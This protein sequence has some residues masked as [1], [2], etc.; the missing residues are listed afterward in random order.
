MPYLLSDPRPVQCSI[1]YVQI[2]LYCPAANTSI[3]FRFAAVTREKPS[4]EQLRREAEELL[5]TAKQL[6][7]KASQLLDKSTALEKKISRN[8]SKAK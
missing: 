5:I 8:S 1:S 6:I 3:T 7:E 4:S 2:S